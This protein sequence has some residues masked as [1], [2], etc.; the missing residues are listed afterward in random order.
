MDNIYGGDLQRGTRAGQFNLP[1]LPRYGTLFSL[2]QV[3]PQTFMSG[4]GRVHA[5]KRC[6]RCSREQ[7]QGIKDL[8]GH[9]AEFLH[10][11]RFFT[12]WDL[13][14]RVAESQAQEST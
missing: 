5:A 6:C 2:T 12:I 9:S 7:L 1:I 3:T 11:V 14:D 4:N 13:L 10:Y 8:F